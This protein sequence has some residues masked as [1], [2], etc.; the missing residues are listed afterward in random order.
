VN[1]ATRLFGAALGVAVIGSIAASLYE[2]RLGAT[3]PPDLPAQATAAATSSIGGALVAAQHLA[4]AG[5]TGP[6]QALA[7]AATGAFLHAMAISLR[8]ASGVALAG[9]VVAAVLLPSR[10]WAPKETAA[11]AATVPVD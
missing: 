7:D 3:L 1:D 5:L 11:E 9:S 4:E 10:P 6:A 8:V 2:H